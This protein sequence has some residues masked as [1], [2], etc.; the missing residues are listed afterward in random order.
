MAT[1]MSVIVRFCRTGLHLISEYD[2]P[3]RNRHS[4]AF[5]IIVHGV[6]EPQFIWWLMWFRIVC[7]H[8]VMA[9]RKHCLLSKGCLYTIILLSIKKILWGYWYAT[10]CLVFL[11]EP[12]LHIVKQTQSSYNSPMCT[13]RSSKGPSPWVN[14]YFDLLCVDVASSMSWLYLRCFANRASFYYRVWMAH[15]DR[16]LSAFYTT[17]L[18]VCGTALVSLQSNWVTWMYPTT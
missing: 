17:W 15:R 14:P 12:G 2:L 13:Y 5:H 6:H 1:S 4:N 11:S 3:H 7:P 10:E 8:E 16:H 18:T 9:S